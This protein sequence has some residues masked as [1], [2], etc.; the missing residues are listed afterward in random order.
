MLETVLKH[1]VLCQYEVYFPLFWTI[2]ILCT[3]VCENDNL[4][5]LLLTGMGYNWISNGEDVTY[6]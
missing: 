2:Y 3:D 6:N 5:E 4:C 1:F